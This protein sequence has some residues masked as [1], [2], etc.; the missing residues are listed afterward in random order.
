MRILYLGKNI[1]N[2]YAASWY[3]MLRQLF[4]T[5]DLVTHGPTQSLRSRWIPNLDYG[6][7]TSLMKIYSRID[8]L[9]KRQGARA[10]ETDVCKIVE[11]VGPEVIVVGSSF[12]QIPA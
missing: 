5:Q 7:A 3:Y 8:R 4:R 6:F 12:P 9:R 2:A 10:L 11:A 1:E